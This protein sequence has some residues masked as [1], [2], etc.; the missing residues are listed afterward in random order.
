MVKGGLSERSAW[1]TKR[2]NPPISNLLTDG[3]RL[4]RL[5]HKSW[6][7]CITL[8]RCQ[9]L[10]IVKKEML[11]LM[12]I[13]LMALSDSNLWQ[14]SVDFT[15][16]MWNCWIAHL[17]GYGVRQLFL[18]DCS[19]SAACAGSEGDPPAPSRTGTVGG[20]V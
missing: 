6:L 16:E 11:L 1:N 5:L 2:D 20:C 4:N 9:P 18:N 13:G 14:I 10:A 12:P 19:T 3:P 17:R 8:I 7:K 15:I